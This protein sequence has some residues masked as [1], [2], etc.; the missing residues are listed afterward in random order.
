MTAIARYAPAVPVAPVTPAKFPTYLGKLTRTTLSV[1]TSE[2]GVNSDLNNA[3]TAQFTIESDASGTT[4]LQKEKPVMGDFM[5]FTS[6]FNYW[7]TDPQ[8][9]EKFTT[10]NKPTGDFERTLGSYAGIYQGRFSAYVD[11]NGVKRVKAFQVKVTLPYDYNGQLVDTEYVV[12]V[13]AETQYGAAAKDQFA[14]SGNGYGSTVVIPKSDLP[15]T[16]TT[17][18]EVTAAATNFNWLIILAIALWLLKRK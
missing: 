12:W 1:Y 2:V 14:V 11:Y 4:F 8:L 3:T 16:T 18:P 15:T 5:I 13:S 17:K 7:Y 10:A 9:G 6:K